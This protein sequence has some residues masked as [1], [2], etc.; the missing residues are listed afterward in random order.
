[1]NIYNYVCMAVIILI[2]IGI[3]LL[4]NRY[5]RHKQGETEKHQSP[6]Q[7]QN[8]VSRRPIMPAKQWFRHHIWFVPPFERPSE[9]GTQ[10]DL[11]PGK[12]Y[13]EGKD[14]G[15]YCQKEKL[16]FLF[17]HE[18]KMAKRT[19]KWGTMFFQLWSPLCQNNSP[20]A[21]AATRQREVSRLIR[22]GKRLQPFS[23][24]L[25][26]PTGKQS[27]HFR[28]IIDTS[29]EA[30]DCMLWLVERWIIT[31][32]EDRFIMTLYNHPSEIEEYLRRN[33]IPLCRD[34]AKEIGK[35]VKVNPAIPRQI[36][37]RFNGVFARE[38]TALIKQQAPRPNRPGAFLYLPKR[39]Q[40]HYESRALAFP[41]G[42]GPDSAV[43]GIYHLLGHE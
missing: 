39:L 43:V 11:F 6:A 12:C 35:T 9:I 3:L 28:E 41:I 37:C 5:R 20:E 40:F 31:G 14:G 32:R 16:P 30:F 8:K 34:T 29:E 42:L 22:H 27:R 4:R 23:I 15:L 17:V 1:M 21:S 24:D 25:V 36:I 2:P 7:T 13:T 33:L 38:I 10:P 19:K 26:M 18:K